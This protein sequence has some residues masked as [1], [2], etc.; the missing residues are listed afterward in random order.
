MKQLVL[1][2]LVALMAA[3]VSQGDASTLRLQQDL[4]QQNRNDARA[5]PGGWMTAYP[6]TATPTAKPTAKPITPTPKPTTCQRAGTYDN[7]C[8]ASPCCAGSTCFCTNCSPTSS[9]YYCV[10]NASL[11]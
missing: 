3:L 10:D 6:T 7:G 8:P 2:L 11:G 9:G 4:L 1:V 5:P